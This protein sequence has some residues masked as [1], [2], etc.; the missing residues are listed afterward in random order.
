MQY[1]TC[2]HVSASSFIG[3]ISTFP[4]Y[5]QPTIFHDSIAGLHVPPDVFP[6]GQSPPDQLPPLE[7]LCSPLQVLQPS[8][9]C[10][11]SE[12]SKPNTPIPLAPPARFLHHPRALRTPIAV[13]CRLLFLLPS[14]LSGQS[15][16]FNSRGR[17]NDR[18][19]VNWDAFT[20]HRTRP[21]H[22]W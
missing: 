21:R 6:E 22:F 7:I 17:P 11:D 12:Q 13:E 5:N 4:S 20:S 14:F 1:K 15:W 18:G 2:N 9:R 19:Q 3:R 8:R 10:S 16:L